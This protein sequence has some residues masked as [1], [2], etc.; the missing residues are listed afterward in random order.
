ML[1][2]ILSIQVTSTDSK[3]DFIQD[4]PGHPIESI[5]LCKNVHIDKITCTRR[6]SRDA[7]PLK[8]DQKRVEYY[9]VNCLAIGLKILIIINNYN[10][11][12][13]QTI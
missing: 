1:L 2:Y 9:L 5:E 10:S 12:S 8:I 3:I 11:Y 13:K 4:C 6:S 7:H